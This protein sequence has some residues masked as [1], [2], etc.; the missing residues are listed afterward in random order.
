MY[1]KKKVNKKK[2]KKKKRI[3]YSVM[4]SSNMYLG[5]GL[6][7]VAYMQISCYYYIKYM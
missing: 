3:Q 4:L 2:K 7:L 5:F 1:E 6:E